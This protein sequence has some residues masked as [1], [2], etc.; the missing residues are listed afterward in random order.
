METGQSRLDRHNRA[1]RAYYGGRTRDTI[2]PAATPYVLRHI[3][4]VLAFG[5]IAPGERVLDAGCGMGRHAFLLAERGIHVEGLDLSPDLLRRLAAHDAGRFGIP[6]HCADLA[7]PPSE[8]ERRFDAVVGFFML[9]HVPDL[10]AVFCGVARVLKPGG[11]AVFIEPN[12]FN[13]LYYIQVTFTPGMKWSAEK[14]IPRMRP[15][16]VLGAAERAGLRAAG[17]ARFGFLPPFLR[18]RAG[19]GHI[20]R[21]L[22]AFPPFRPFL[23]F[24]LFRA[25]KPAA[26]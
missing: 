4:E 12:A 20:E 9:H 14:G 18:N 22:E 11:R 5:G 17:F 25:D 16:V 1:Q 7:K 6:T 24:Q 10:D 23:P 3:D 8:L 19:G 21:L 13:P 2:A 26:A 15:R